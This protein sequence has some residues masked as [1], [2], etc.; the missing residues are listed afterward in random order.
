M[1][2]INKVSEI[3]DFLVGYREKSI[4]IFG[5]GLDLRAPIQPLFSVQA[6]NTPGTENCVAK[7][8]SELN[9]IT[10]DA[11]KV[12]DELAK[13]HYEWALD[14][15]SRVRNR[16]SQEQHGKHP[17]MPKEEIK[18]PSPYLSYLS[19]QYDGVDSPIVGE[20]LQNKRGY[21]VMECILLLLNQNNSIEYGKD[22]FIK[23]SA[24][25]LLLS[26]ILRGMKRQKSLHCNVMDFH[27]L[28]DILFREMVIMR[29]SGFALFEYVSCLNIVIKC[30]SSTK[31][32]YRWG[33]ATSLLSVTE[34]LIEGF[35]VMSQ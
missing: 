28:V 8:S 31:E 20:I 32:K 19:S 10:T 14:N 22:H 23:Y 12:L 29:D 16:E 35:G 17:G 2:D 1:N 11:A 3:I 25:M 33:E 34:S 24:V 27:V 13:M 15:Y 18:A 9:T 21:I 26:D 5:S 7:P 4:R 30:I 6:E